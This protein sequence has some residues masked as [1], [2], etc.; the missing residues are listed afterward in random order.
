MRAKIDGPGCRRVPLAINIAGDDSGAIADCRA[1]D[2]CFARRRN[3]PKSIVRFSESG[4]KAP[5]GGN[6]GE[7]V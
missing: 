1:F 3:W 7:R 2:E 5:A 4:N 6:L